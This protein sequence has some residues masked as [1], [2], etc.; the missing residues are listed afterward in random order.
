MLGHTQEFYSSRILE[1]WYSELQVLLRR[2][3]HGLGN[4]C[5]ARRDTH[6][7]RVLC[8]ATEHPVEGESVHCT[9]CDL[10]MLQLTVGITRER[11]GAE[12]ARIVS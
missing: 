8:I 12:K 7:Q 9:T 1:F 10:D 5:P 11:Q 6:V 3:A 4:V 2:L